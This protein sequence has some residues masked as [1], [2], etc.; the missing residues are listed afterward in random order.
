MT[1]LK[2]DA[3]KIY[4][5]N[6]SKYANQEFA[7]L[8]PLDNKVK[9][10]KTGLTIGRIVADPKKEKEAEMAKTIMKSDWVAGK[11]VDKPIRDMQSE[12]TFDQ[13]AEEQ[14][15]EKKAQ[16]RMKS[17]GRSG[18]QAGTGRRQPYQEERRIPQ[19]PDPALLEPEPDPEKERMAI[20]QEMANRFGGTPINDSSR[21]G[22]YGGFRFGGRGR[23]QVSMPSERSWQ[24]P[25][26]RYGKPISSLADSNLPVGGGFTEKA[27]TSQSQPRMRRKAEDIKAYMAA[28]EK[29]EEDSDRSS[30]SMDEIEMER[31]G[32]NKSSSSDDESGS[33]KEDPDQPRII[34]SRRFGYML[35]DGTSV[36][37]PEE[38]EED[39]HEKEKKRAPPRSK[40]QDAVS[41]NPL[42]DLREI[43]EEKGETT[44]KRRGGVAGHKEVRLVGAA[45]QQQ[46]EENQRKR[47]EQQSK[48]MALKAAQEEIERLKE[49]KK[50]KE[51]EKKKK[52]KMDEAIEEQ[53]N[54]G[55]GLN[56]WIN[57][58][59][60]QEQSI[61]NQK[62]L[63]ENQMN[64]DKNTRRRFI[65]S[66]SDSPQSSISP[67][68]SGTAVQ[69][70]DKFYD[71]IRDLITT[72]IT[73]LYGTT[74]D[75][76]LYP[77]YMK[78]K[79]VDEN[80]LLQLKEKTDFV[81]P[82]V[83]LRDRISRL[84]MRSQDPPGAFNI[85]TD[86]NAIEATD[87]NTKTN[88]NEEEEHVFVE[89][90]EIVVIEEEEIIEE[91]PADQA[92]E[93]PDNNADLDAQ[94]DD[95]EA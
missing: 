9:F 52:N 43:E 62:M 73:D 72:T 69:L 49:A 93:Q 5:Q 26:Q 95:E 36:K 79:P 83:V 50:Q 16:K 48:I 39:K 82:G 3:N 22:G 67:V 58:H 21:R 56:R 23:Q 65:P 91:V 10:H 59:E 87:F 66:Q 51:Q 78:E 47:E 31:L 75:R 53:L 60:V 86:Y 24:T 13:I 2:P 25:V 92:K 7:D 28:H 74:A 6:N 14:A 88:F 4:L 90:E 55:K 44:V 34:Y 41:I 30:S 11:L 94:A 40:Y 8:I 32:L 54:Q 35:P 45:A 89:E 68:S 12:L 80:N 71:K 27:V 57:V 81:R 84:P 63:E 33:I 29:K 61:E 37:M 46:E 76:P 38:E 18:M 20:Q 19:R 64:K 70:D 85:D 77:L 17:W 15:A 1:S 42:Y